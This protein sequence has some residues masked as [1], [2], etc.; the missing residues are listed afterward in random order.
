MKSIGYYSI[1]TYCIYLYYNCLT[2]YW[3]VDCEHLVRTSWR[4]CVNFLNTWCGEWEHF[5]F[6]TLLKTA[7]CEDL[8]HI[9]ICVSIYSGT[10]IFKYLYIPISE[11]SNIRVCVYLS[12]C[13]CR[14]LH[15]WISAYINI[16]MYTSICEY[17]QIFINSWQCNADCCRKYVQIFAVLY[18]FI[19]KY[20]KIFEYFF[21]FSW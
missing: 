11:H 16:L 21:V 9:C 19:P 2:P 6:P 15:S 13:I 14:Y 10:L 18:I 3:C 5:T 4:L 20:F 7:R 1:I 12:F 17:P 8:E